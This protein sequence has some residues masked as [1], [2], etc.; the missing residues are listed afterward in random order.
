MSTITDLK[1]IKIVLETALLTAEE[2]LTVGQLKKLFPEEL[3][4][5]L[6]NGLVEEIQQDWRGRG[7]ELV[8][9][10]SGWRF[11]ARAEFAPYLA[12]L[13]RSERHV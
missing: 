5:A 13:T 2:P 7:V 9:L 1:Y 12:R 10:A 6:I 8:K 3:K 4:T 11:R